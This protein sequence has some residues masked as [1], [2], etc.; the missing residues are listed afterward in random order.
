MVDQRG[1]LAITEGHKDVNGK[2]KAP[3]SGWDVI[4][5]PSYESQ[6]V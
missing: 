3:M 5:A 1:A 2:D 6:S 4:K